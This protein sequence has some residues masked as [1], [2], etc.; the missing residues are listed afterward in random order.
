MC[1]EVSIDDVSVHG[2]DYHLELQFLSSFGKD[3]H[4]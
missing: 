3:C 4:I 2:L 1:E